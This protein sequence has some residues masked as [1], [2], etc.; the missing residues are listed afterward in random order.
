MRRGPSVHASG[1]V[2][3]HS[4]GVP[5]HHTKGS[6]HFEGGGP[7]TDRDVATN[8][9]AALSLALDRSI[10]LWLDGLEV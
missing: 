4:E 8:G 6:D 1:T 7:I 3:P 9:E 5:H 2:M 10:R